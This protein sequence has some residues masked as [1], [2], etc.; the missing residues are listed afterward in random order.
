[1]GSTS[2]FFLATRTCRQLTQLTAEDSI[3]NSNMF[4]RSAFR[5]AQPLKTQARRYAT[6]SAPKGGS[7]TLLYAAGA[8]GLGGRRPGLHLAEAVRGGECQPQHQALPLRA[9]RGRHGLWP[10]HR[11]CHPDQVQGPQ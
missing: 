1:M 6:E 8:A 7:N 5:A 10:P 9:A 4:A 11:Q 2:L 3:T